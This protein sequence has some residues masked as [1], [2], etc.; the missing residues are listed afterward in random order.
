MANERRQIFQA[1]ASLRRFRSGP[2]RIL[3]QYPESAD[4]RT[5][6]L[7]AATN[8][9]HSLE[10][11]I[12]SHFKG[13]IDKLRQILLSGGH[14][15]DGAISTLYAKSWL[16]HALGDFGPHTMEDLTAIRE[17]RNTFAHSIVDITFDTIPVA[18]ACKLKILDRIP[19]KGGEHT[20]PKTPKG[21]Y[22]FAVKLLSGLIYAVTHSP[23]DFPEDVMQSFRFLLS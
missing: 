9:E 20:R 5:V 15:G 23:Q 17:I 8:L 7:V 16:A 10:D 19:W 18:K 22:M 2:L 14:Q 12:A 1:L 4:D 13:D 11:A 3:H 21:E 6:A